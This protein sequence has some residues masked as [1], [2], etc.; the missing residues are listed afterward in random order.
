MAASAKGKG[1]AAGAAA[2]QAKNKTNDKKR[3]TPKK[4]KGAWSVVL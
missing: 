3:I 2:K 4:P 1:Q